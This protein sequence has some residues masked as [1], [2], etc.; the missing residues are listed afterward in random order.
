VRSPIGG[1]ARLLG[2]RTT[3]VLVAV[4]VLAGVLIAS[5]VALVA[6]LHRSLLSGL[7]AQISA[8]ARDVAAAAASGQLGPVISNTGDEVSLVQ[9]LGP[10][11]Q[12]RA[13][14]GNIS[15]E[16]PLV[17]AGAALAAPGTER[18]TNLPIG[19]GQEIF[20]V[21]SVSVS[22]AGGTGRVVVA[23][24]TAPVDAAV[25][26]VE[27]LL[28]FGLPAVVSASGLVVWLTLGRALRP[29]ERI[30]EQAARLGAGELSQRVPVPPGRDEIARLADAPIDVKW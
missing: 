26:R 27:S 21:S 24:S 3:S 5:S 11:G 17:G 22:L 2:V 8:R 13:A 7:D 28:V 10:H 23:A 6:V 9:V 25:H 4:T 18:V 1:Q 30:R 19:A 12:V 20:R 29:V 15:G 14:T 16:P